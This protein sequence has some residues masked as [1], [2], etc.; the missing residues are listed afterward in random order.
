MQRLSPQ[1]K[2]ET[3]IFYKTFLNRTYHCCKL[4]CL[5]RRYDTLHNDTQHND[6]QHN[7]SQHNNSQHN[8][9]QHNDSQHN[10]SQHNDI[11]HNDTLHYDIQYKRK[12]K[13][14]ETLS[15]MTLTIIAGYA[16]CHL[17]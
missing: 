5:P 13:E 10:D 8:D 4:A 6:S 11:Q 2:G 1:S 7:D 16:K 3:G 9:S 14:N 17:C 15:I 12:E